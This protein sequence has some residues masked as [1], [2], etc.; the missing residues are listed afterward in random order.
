MTS[1]PENDFVSMSDALRQK[2]EEGL[3]QNESD[4]DLLT[5]DAEAEQPSDTDL[6]TFRE[7]DVE[8]YEE[9]KRIADAVA[10]SVS[11]EEVSDEELEEILRRYLSS[12]GTTVVKGAVATPE[13]QEKP[14]SE[15]EEHPA[16]EPA[17][18][19]GADLEKD[20]EDLLNGFE[21]PDADESEDG[22]PGD[23][24]KSHEVAESVSDFSEEEEPVEEVIYEEPVQNEESAEQPQEEA[25]EEAG[26]GETDDGNL[27]EDTTNE[28]VSDEDSSQEP[29]LDIPNPEEPLSL[30]DP[31]VA[32]TSMEEP[33]E[34][35][36]SEGEPAEVPSETEEGVS[37]SEQADERSE[38]EEIPEGSPAAAVQETDAKDSAPSDEADLS[39][40][41]LGE[42]GDLLEGIS[43]GP[44]E[45]A[46]DRAV[47]EKDDTAVEGIDQT[48]IDLAIAFGLENELEKERDGKEA[49]LV[50]RA[51]GAGR[52]RH[53]NELRSSERTT[54]PSSHAEYVSSSQN[55]EI[56]AEYKKKYESVLLRLAAAVILTIL[57][58]FLENNTLL[59]ITLPS[60]LNREMYPIVYVLIDLQIVLLLAA[61]IGNS[62][63]SGI[64]SLFSKRPMPES[65]TVTLLIGAAVYTAVIA[66]LCPMHGLQMYN[67]PIS[68][69]ILLHLIAEFM[70][71]RREIMTFKIISSRKLKYVVD[72]ISGEET[73]A[74]VS[75]FSKYLMDDPSMFRIK[76]TE[77]VD[78][79]FRR[80]EAY[81]VSRL[82]LRLAIPVGV[83]IALVF[84][85]VQFVMTRQLYTSL[86]TS[87]ISLFLTLPAGT[88]LALSYPMY[89]ASRISY[90]RDSAFIGEA[91]LGEYADASVVTFDDK[92]VFPGRLAR[93]QNVRMYGDSRIDHVM[94]AA[95]SVFHAVGGPLAEVFE[96]AS[97]E[98][99]YASDVTLV[100]IQ[101]DGIE[102]KLGEDTVL[103]GKCSFMNR[104]G[105]EIRQS[106]SEITGEKSGERPMLYVALRNS[107]AAAFS[108]RYAVEPDFEL[109]LKQL[110]RQNVCVGIKTS[111]PNIDD[112]L[113]AQKI[114]LS[115]YPIR[116]IKCAQPEETEIVVERMSSG[117]VSRS[118][119]KALLQ[120]LAMCER[121]LSAN[122]TNRIIR[123][124]SILLAVAAIAAFVALR[125]SPNIAPIWIVLYQLFWCIPVVI[126]S[127]YTI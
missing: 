48:D 69:A 24:T 81:P 119:A 28:P 90:D 42:L 84:F 103:C 115:K 32:E 21:F 56:F 86:N 67:F 88:L 27:P 60:F 62:L 96:T 6:D 100:S 68:F 36:L 46:P 5:A 64:K 11:D 105:Y 1:T 111:D 2:L 9:K 13:P 45:K 35:I 39:E 99:G 113:L 47:Q 83:L 106:E 79:Y 50:H 58:F 102:A 59:G 40:E 15:A 29:I 93:I 127:R 91:S 123:V 110:Y 78:H 94:Y 101:E 65:L 41:D 95:A 97:G 122:R 118:G 23:E 87:Y 37:G 126:L 92:E 26:S 16:A 72:S 70:N 109:V 73:K 18:A 74:E 20:I 112:N 82:A 33:Q 108:L 77:F 10:A 17:E 116:I 7:S 55:K 51:I 4:Q 89:H 121:I 38:A 3:R 31:F 53:I 98:I 52:R 57:L 66:S 34:E 25:S 54:T 120:T 49:D 80:T 14:S 124:L 30:E 104:Y 117:I 85:C 125:I 75:L 71:L 22:E 12:N 8:N 114:K 43:E 44:D 107:M 76:Q 63:K 19:E 61:L